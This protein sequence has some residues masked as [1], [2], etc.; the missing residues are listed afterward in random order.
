MNTK[1]MSFSHIRKGVL[2]RIFYKEKGMG[3][4]PIPYDRDR[5]TQR[6]RKQLAAPYIQHK[7][8]YLPL[9]RHFCQG[10]KECQHCLP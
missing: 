3:S 8:I 4:V 6:H 1:T 10:Y 7:K 5:N 2:L 9:L